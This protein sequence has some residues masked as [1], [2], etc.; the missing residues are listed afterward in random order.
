MPHHT[1]NKVKVYVRTRPTNNFASDMI[2]VGRDNRTVSVHRVA[3]ANAV[4]NKINDWAFHLDG[5]FHNV[6]QDEIFDSVA[7][8]VIDRTLDGYNG[9][10]M[11]YGQTGAGKTHTMTGFTESY[12]NRGVIPRTIQHIFQEINSRQDFSYSIRIAYLEIYNDQMCDL[13]RTL[14]SKTDNQQQQQQQLSIGEDVGFVYVKGL[15]YRIAN[16][17]EEALNLLFEGETNRS[18][19]QHVLNKQSS[20][21]HCIFTIIVECRSVLSSD[22]KYTVS[23]LNLVDL[24]GSERLAKTNSEG[25]TKREATFINKSLS[26]LEQVVLNLSDKKTNCSHFRSSKLTHALKDSIGGRCN[27]VM[28]ANIWPELQHIEET[29]ST[30][31]FASRMMCVPAEPTVNEIIDPVKAIENYKR[32]N[33]YLKEELALHNTLVNRNGISYEPLSEQQLYEI[34]NQC[35]RFIDGSL[36]EVEI[37]NVR[38]VQAV[39]NT[40]KNICRATEKDV[41][42]KYRDRY[43]LTDKHD[44]DQQDG[45]KLSGTTQ[46]ATSIGGN[47]GELDGQSFGIGTASKDQRVSKD[48]LLKMTRN[49]RQATSK[50]SPGQQQQ[51]T[52]KEKSSPLGS[53]PTGA[54]LQ[55]SSTNDEEQFPRVKEPSDVADMK[56]QPPST[57]P[58]RTIAFEEFKQT[59]GLNLNKIYLE[60]KEI[61]ASKKKQFADLA[62]GINQMK[63]DID[64]TRTDAEH[65]KNERLTMGEFLNENGETIIDEEE[66]ELIAKLQELK[67]IYRNDYDQWKDLKSEI[68]YCQ[69]LVNQCQHRLLQEFDIWYNEC[70]SNGNNATDIDDIIS[71]NKVTNEYQFYDDAAERFERMQKELLLSDLDSM[72]FRQAQ[73][74]TNRRHVF[75]AARTQGPWKQ[76]PPTTT[77]NNTGFRSGQSYAQEIFSLPAISVSAGRQK[78]MVR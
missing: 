24:A 52:P 53:K 15:S 69:N 59:R 56:D 62:R 44:Y 32:E 26:F 1:T 29:V 78:S 76:A 57:P 2:S 23:K 40:L 70:Y 9:T 28:I 30:L 46:G 21:S 51:P 43:V 3:S 10:I 60:N 49:K 37:Q 12:P 65:K 61:L 38:Q 16:S 25:V 36:D 33:K 20:R 74:R 39:F 58:T 22:D 18:I 42:K 47:S 54:T 72:P 75:N 48:A 55:R 6:S 77:A 14:D 27:T 17:E 8:D 19:G 13:L 34:E 66:Y 5:V 11:C 31:R 71:S 41:E 4:D 63:T 68:N 7:K 35:R 67:G 64:K 45:Q 73:M 50:T